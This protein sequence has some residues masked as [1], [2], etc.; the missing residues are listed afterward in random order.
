MF[1]VLRFLMLTVAATQQPAQSPPAAA[2]TISGSVVDARTSA[3]LDRATV[4]LT[5]SDGFGLLRDAGGSTGAFALAR[6]VTTSVTGAY[7]FTELSIGAYRLRIQ[8]VGYE[9]S[10]VDVRLEDAGTPS[11]SIGLVVLPVRLHAVEVRAHDSITP[12]TMTVMDGDARVAAA[13]AR[14][15]AYLSTDARELT[16][17][18]VTESA[19]LGGSDVLRAFQRL[20]G[21]TQLDDWSAELWVR[22]NRWDHNRV[23]YDGLP[24][25][26]PLGVLGRTSGVSADAIGG[27]FLHPGV[28]PVSLGGDGATR[29][30]LQSRPALAGGAW[31]GTAEVTQFGASGSVE[32]ARADTSAGFL[33]TAQHSLGDV[34]PRDGLFFDALAGRSFSDEQ[35]TARGDI[36]LGGGRR[37]ETSGLFGRDARITPHA[38]IGDETTQEWSNALGRLTF[39]APFGSVTTGHSIGVSRFASHSDRLIVGS[40]NPVASSVDHVTLS[41]RVAARTPQQRVTTAGYD[42]T[43]EQ[44][45]IDGTQQ[46]LAWFDLAQALTSRRTALTYGSLWIDDRAPLGDRVTIENGLRLDV[47]GGHGLDAVRPAASAQ[48]VLS[49]SPSTRASIG[50]S[51]THQYVQ[52][53]DL[54]VVGQGETLPGSWLTS[55]GDVPVMSVDNAMAGVERWI[56]TGVLVSMNGYVRHTMGAITADPTPG[57]VMHRPLFVDASESARGLEVSARKLIGRAS[58]LLAYT[59]GSATMHAGGLSF[60][61]PADRTHA[62]DAALSLHFAS[63]TLG[64]SYALTSGAPYTRIIAVPPAGVSNA[65]G[66]FPT[67]RDAPNAQRLPAYASLDLLFTYAH[68]IGAAKLVAFAGAQNA[69][70]RKNVTWYE[71]SGYCDNGQSQPTASAQCRDHDVVQAPVK[72]APTLGVRLVV[73]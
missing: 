32:R 70:N 46:S 54:P 50:A 17:A 38:N 37:I 49:L 4:T 45:S 34:L 30:D 63:F 65:S 9:P 31:R 10:T 20:P 14:Q 62:L 59:Y 57:P 40:S 19:T 24:L 69:L 73:R 28:R 71:I 12:S 11:V 72:L 64:A 41:G 42:V 47:G 18:D 29:I 48:A 3:P 33:V 56:G 23:Y 60:P 25:F 13:R 53:I 5:S 15:E 68:A 16:S 55:G 7:R 39:L 8:R 6:T 66:L 1:V 67:E 36:D 58:G 26:D 35:A 61:A 22:G 2:G 51:R 27:A 43:S 21:V 44:S 52:A